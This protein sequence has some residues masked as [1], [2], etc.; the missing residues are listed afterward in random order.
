[1]R[2]LTAPGGPQGPGRRPRQDR[3]DRGDRR[4]RRR[5]HRARSRAWSTLTHGS[6]VIAAIT[7]CT[8]TSNPD[9]MIAAG[10]VARK[11]NALGLTRK[12]WV[13]TSL[14]PGSKVVTEYLDK[15][16][17]TEDLDALG[18]QTV[19]YGCT[20]CIG[21]SGPLPPEIEAAIE[22]GRPRGRVDPVGQPQLR[23]PRPPQRARQLPRQP[24]ARRRLRDRGHGRHRPRNEPLTPT[25]DGKDGLPQG[26]L[27]H[28]GGDRRDHTAAS[29]PSSSPQVR[30]PSR[31]RDL[32]RGPRL[33]SELYGWE[34]ASHLHPEPALLRGHGRDAPGFSPIAR[35]PRALPLGDSSPPTTSRPRAASSPRPPPGSTCSTPASPRRT[36]T[37]SAHAAATTAS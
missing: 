4:P 19:G 6:I 9:V 10:L 27:A 37:P 26:H 24:P 34:D 12:P 36:S 30:R 15:S 16:N 31:E 25:P 22:E 28:Q 2:A 7:S 1:M 32:E 35:R 17:L 21:N 18:F 33:Q 5:A 8:N 14:A 29:P 20:T 3:R 13:K 11:A 23:G